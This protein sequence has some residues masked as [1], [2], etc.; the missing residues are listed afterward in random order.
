MQCSRPTLD[1]PRSRRKRSCVTIDWQDNQ[2]VNCQAGTVEWQATVAPPPVTGGANS[3]GEFTPMQ[4]RFAPGRAGDAG[5]LPQRAGTANGVAVCAGLGLWGRQDGKLRTNRRGLNWATH[6][7]LM[8][9]SRVVAVLQAAVVKVAFPFVQVGVRAGSCM[10][11]IGVGPARARLPKAALR[12]PGKYQGIV[13]SGQPSPKTRCRNGA[14]DS[15]ADR[16][17]R[18]QPRDFVPER[19]QWPKDSCGTGAA[20]AAA[21]GRRQERTGRRGNRR[22]AGE[23]QAGRASRDGAVDVST[24]PVWRRAWR[25][26]E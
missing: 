7:L 2:G 24:R 12:Q 5:P 20:A 9:A 13:P 25:T 11:H 1:G 21:V 26:E 15:D 17:S 19:L 6:T 23:R 14:P 3:I 18:D 10:R 16:V 8:M 22:G 4:A